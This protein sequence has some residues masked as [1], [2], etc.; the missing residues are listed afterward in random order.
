MLLV[1]RSNPG[2]TDFAAALLAQLADFAAVT[3][4]GD[5]P[6]VI[7]FTSGTTG[8]PKG[9]R[10]PLRILLALAVYILDA[11]DLRP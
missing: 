2:A 10:W 11:I 7:M 6:F 5:D 3:L 9:V 4:R 1:D 8:S